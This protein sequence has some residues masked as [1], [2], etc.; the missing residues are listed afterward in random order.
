M[1]S[2]KPNTTTGP[3]TAS[4]V[5]VLGLA[6]LAVAL[7]LGMVLIA[8]GEGRS[9]VLSW[10]TSIL[11][12]V[13]AGTGT[14]AVVQSRRV[15]AGVQVVQQQ[16]NGSLD[17]RIAEQMTRVLDERLPMPTGGGSTS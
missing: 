5:L 17:R 11:G 6:V 1:T 4:V 9:E 16:T 13:A 14:G 2:T 10:L 3:S 15:L 12:L 8:G 7:I